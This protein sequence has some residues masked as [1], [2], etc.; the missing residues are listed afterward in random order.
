MSISDSCFMFSK[1]HASEERKR[2]L[3]ISYPFGVT[4][5]VLPLVLALLASDVDLALRMRME[6]FVI[7]VTGSG[8]T[9][10]CTAIVDAWN[11]RLQPEDT[12]DFAGYSRKEKRSLLHALRVTNERIVA[13]EVMLMSLRSEKRNAILYDEFHEFWRGVPESVA[14]F[15]L[16]KFINTTATIGCFHEIFQD[17]IAPFIDP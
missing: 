16:S 14:A 10:V 15:Y 3:G 6:I 17:K 2:F 1:Q 9:V 11:H 8:P 12:Y 13:T 7:A 4:S 5:N